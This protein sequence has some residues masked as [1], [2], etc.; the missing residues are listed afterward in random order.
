MNRH[1][2]RKSIV[3]RPAGFTLVELLVV[4]GIIALLISI[5]LPSLQKA[6]KQATQLKCA[7]NLR[8]LGAAMVI[9]SNMNKGV[10]LPTIIWGNPASGYSGNDDSWAHLLVISG[11]V[12]PPVVNDPTS[13]EAEESVLVCPEVRALRIASNVTVPVVVAG[14]GSSTSTDGYERRQSKHL[15]PG[16]I[17]DYGYGINGS[18]Q[19]DGNVGNVVPSTSIAV[20]GFA[21]KAPPLKKVSSIR[22][23]SDMVIMY[24]GVAWNPWGARERCAGSRHGKFDGTTTTSRFRTGKTN[25]LF[26]DGHV[27]TADRASLPETELQWR[28]TAAQKRNPND[29]TFLFNVDQI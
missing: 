2:M 14:E 7:N 23:N 28:G 19:P 29:D 16:L 22:R 13:I 8:Q 9:Y 11:L 27:I 4:I 21:F 5:L 3:R 25:V 18:T 12:T 17:V 24:D 6:R 20:G 26:L 10:V 15:Q 1:H